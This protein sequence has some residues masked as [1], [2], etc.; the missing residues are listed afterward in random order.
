M[1]PHT[2]DRKSQERQRDM[3]KGALE[4]LWQSRGFKPTTLQLALLA[5]L[6]ARQGLLMNYQPTY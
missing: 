1:I 3:P 5:A 2:A 6:Q 4:G